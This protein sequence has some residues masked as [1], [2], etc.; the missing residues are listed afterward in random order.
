MFNYRISKYNPKFVNE[1]GTYTKDEWKSVSDIGEHFEDSGTLTGAQYMKVEKQY[2]NFF[3]DLLSNLKIRKIKISNQKPE[4][5]FW[6]TEFKN[7]NSTDKDWLSIIF[8]NV[9]REKFKCKFKAKDVVINGEKDYYLSIT[10][11][12]NLFD[13]LSEIAKNNNLF[14]EKV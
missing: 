2:V 7:K 10:S 11:K 14:C 12:T 9:M 4:R 1:N 5:V 3:F 13:T 6:K 8:Q